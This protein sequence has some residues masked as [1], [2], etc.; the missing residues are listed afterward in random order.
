MTSL[1]GFGTLKYNGLAFNGP[2]VNSKV[3]MEPVYG[4]DDR[5]VIFT[6]LTIE[7]QAIVSVDTCGVPQDDLTGTGYLSSIDAIRHM[8][9]QAGKPLYF[10]DK[11]FGEIRVNTGNSGDLIDVNYGPRVSLGSIT[12]VG[13]NRSFEVVWRVTTA[14]GEC[15]E[16][17]GFGDLTGATTRSYAIGDI[18]QCVYEIAWS[19]DHR[20][21]SRR[22][23]SGFIEIV[24]APA[25]SGDV[26]DISA[27]DYR[28]RLTVSLPLGFTRTTNEWK[29]NSR[30]DRANFTIVDEEI[31]S[32]H[33]YPPNVVDIEVTH[34]ASV[35]RPHVTKAVIKLSGHCEV[36]PPNGA[37]IAFDRL[38]PI[39]SSRLSS[40]RASAGA[41]Y[42]QSVTFRESLYSP[43]V[44]FSIEYY[45]LQSSI[46]GFVLDSG[47]FSDFDSGYRT[48][49][50]TWRESMFGPSED[51]EEAGL[52]LSRR[53]VAELSFDPADD[54]IVTPCKTQPFNISIRNA[55]SFNNPVA[56][57]GM[58]SNQCPSRRASYVV[59]K[60]TLT[61]V[62][63]SGAA[64]LTEMP[65][66]AYTYTI[67]TPKAS[68]GETLTNATNTGA[69]T[70]RTFDANASAPMVELILEGHAAR[71]GF[72]VELPKVAE[73]WSKD[74]SKVPRG[75]EI[76]STSRMHLGCKLY[77]SAW[78]IKYLITQSLVDSA[79][80]LGDLHD[81]LFITTDYTTG[82]QGDNV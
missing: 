62:N 12:P 41:I 75:S 36:S 25:I 21:Y 35:G 60:S 9:S 56:S 69:Q 3:S 24:Q 13:A 4:D 53:S 54:V 10:E 66:A 7:V 73:Q 28:E 77:M 15:P 29:L 68:S 74:V 65:T 16:R 27:D 42:I 78:R 44:E 6:N 46:R 32:P 2:M 26:I 61:S 52:P 14:I 31:A 82:D 64:T 19:A 71:L 18:K 20:G 59:Y 72:A 11:V 67:D 30:R 50:S 51:T 70:R 76:K 40:A 63:Q 80:S 5:A 33:A 1:S 34:E 8:L 38:Y 43:R 22:A 58:L 47:M 48:D 49:W 37:N 81:T 39:I 55:R 79:T 23:T 45:Q 17:N 57:L